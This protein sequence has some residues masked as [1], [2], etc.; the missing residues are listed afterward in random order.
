MLP[1][2]AVTIGAFWCYQSSDS[3]LPM[4]GE[5]PTAPSVDRCS[6]GVPRGRMPL[7]SPVCKPVALQTG[8]LPPFG[9][10]CSSTMFASA[11]RLFCETAAEETE[12]NVCRGRLYYRKVL[13][14]YRVS[15]NTVTPFY[16]NSLSLRNHISH[17]G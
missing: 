11:K 10:Y 15:G 9:R 7:A 12:G 13:P 6:D 14:C 17:F 8:S 1:E 5:A 4:G 16:N 2:S 3:V